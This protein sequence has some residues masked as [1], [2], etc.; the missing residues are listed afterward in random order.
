MTG[1]T[2]SVRQEPVSV[3]EVLRD[4][5]SDPAQVSPLKKRSATTPGLIR[6]EQSRR[7]TNECDS[8]VSLVLLGADPMN[9]LRDGE[10]K[11]PSAREL[12]P[13]D[14]IEVR[15]GNVIPADVLWRYALLVWGYA[16][17]WF[18]VNSVA[19][20]VA[21]HLIERGAMHQVKHLGRVEAVLHPAS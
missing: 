4:L 8:E 6:R 5:Q 11:N 10:W 20:I 2:E 12:V 17:A 14:V 16:I 18:L 9:T 1:A 13:G 15:L 21:Y 7:G 19:K 3:T